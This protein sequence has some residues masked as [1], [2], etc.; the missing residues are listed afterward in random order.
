MSEIIEQQENEIREAWLKYP[1]SGA[2]TLERV[3]TENPSPDFRL[4]FIED[5]AAVMQK[6]EEEVESLKIE[7]DKI[8]AL[9]NKAVDARMQ[10]DIRANT[11][12]RELTAA[13]E[14]EE[15]FVEAL[16][17]AETILIAGN[18]RGGRAHLQVVEALAAF[19]ASRKEQL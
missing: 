16:R 8:H 18:W 9:H 1:F 14:R 13:K 12:E 6:R 4:G 11:A 19:G 2:K 10:A 17:G 3:E 5:Y 15:K 7:C